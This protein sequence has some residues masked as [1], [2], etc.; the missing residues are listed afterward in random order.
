MKSAKIRIGI[1]DYIITDSGDGKYVLPSD[2]KDH[3]EAQQPRRDDILPD[4]VPEFSADWLAQAEARKGSEACMLPGCPN[5]KRLHHLAKFCSYKHERAYQA[6]R[7]RRRQRG[8]RQ[9]IESID[10]LPIR[11]ERSFPRSMSRAKELLARHVAERVCQY[12]GEDD[13]CPSSH[14]PYNDPS[15]PRCLIYAV[16]A[17]DLMVWRGRNQGVVVQRRYTTEDGSWKD[18]LW[19]SGEPTQADQNSFLI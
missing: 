12:G 11:F 4:Q 15:K 18:G 5:K 16:M 2:V 10:S 7:Y 3:L 17:D 9:W 13:R 19:K 6:R 8:L 14:N 1:Q